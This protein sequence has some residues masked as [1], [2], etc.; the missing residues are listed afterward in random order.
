MLLDVAHANVSAQNMGYQDVNEFLQ[1]LPLEEVVEIHIAGAGRRY[2]LA[3][4]TH[5]PIHRE[6]QPEAS[7]LE[8]LLRS[9]RMTRLKAITLETFEDVIPQLELLREV[10]QRCGYEIASCSGTEG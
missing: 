1:Q 9:G 2:G 7:Y 5:I 6:G 10:L 8:N 4:D 3:H